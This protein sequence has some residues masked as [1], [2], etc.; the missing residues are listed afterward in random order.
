M[1][2]EPVSA[3][4]TAV[5]L[6]AVGVVFTF[7]TIATFIEVVWVVFGVVFCTPGLLSCLVG[8]RKRVAVLVITCLGRLVMVVCSRFFFYLLKGYLRGDGWLRMGSCS[9]RSGWWKTPCML[10]DWPCCLLLIWL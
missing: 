1:A 5:E 8:C 6:F 3:V 4:F 2:N 10:L 7:A 9:R